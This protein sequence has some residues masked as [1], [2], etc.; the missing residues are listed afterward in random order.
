[1]NKHKLLSVLIVAFLGAVILRTFVVEGFIVI[2]DSMEP[3]IKSGEYVFV[4]KLGYA[5]SEPKRGDVVVARPRGMD[6][7]VI[8]RII[9]LPMERISIENGKVV[10]REG[11]L[12]EGVMLE[13]IYLNVSETASSGISHINLDPGEYFA[14]GDNR[15]VSIDS[16]E[17]GPIDRWDIRGKVI[18][19]LNLVHLIYKGF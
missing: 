2:G 13:E 4:N 1:M 9:G 17:L 11:R 18:G 7:K 10:I 19:S 6:Q 15:Q 12:D 3:A 14:L 5:W 16:R 8:K